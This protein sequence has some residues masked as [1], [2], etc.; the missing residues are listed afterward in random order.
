MKEKRT[1]E[2]LKKQYEKDFQKAMSF[3]DIIKQMMLEYDQLEDEVV[4]LME[5]SA[6]CLN[7]LKEIALKPNP[8]STPE[9]IDLLIEG[10]KSEA[11]PGYQERIKKLQHMRGKAVTM[12][13]VA[14]GAK[15][16]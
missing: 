9:Y 14:R 1:Y 12:G 8:L 15:L 16:L 7:T 11:K 6:Q 2:Q 3:E 5:L 13:L 4:Q 10:E